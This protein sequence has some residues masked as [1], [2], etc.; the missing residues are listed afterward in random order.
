MGVSALGETRTQRPLGITLVVTSGLRFPASL[1]SATLRLSMATW[2]VLSIAFGLVSMLFPGVI[3]SL[4]EQATN[5]FLLG[6]WGWLTAVL[7]LGVL[8]ASRDPVRHILWLRIAIL[9]FAVGGAY[10]IAHVMADT[11]SLSAILADLAAYSIFGTLFVVFY[12]KAPRWMALEVRT[13]RGPLF[14]NVDEGGVFFQDEKTGA[15]ARYSPPRP[16][17][18]INSPYM[19]PRSG[20]FFPSNTFRP[21]PSGPDPAAWG[22]E[23][24]S[25]PPPNEPPGD[26]PRR[27]LP[28]RS[29]IFEQR[30]ER[31][32]S[33]GSLEPNLQEPQKEQE[34]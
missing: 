14:T 4:G 8:F 23:Q 17:P 1:R 11:A 22:P 31:F 5:T 15:F 10:N 24:P 28:P 33:H 29:N 18:P 32:P 12:P 3:G 21:D 2:G 6:S 34:E 7:G 30:A 25:A 16:N 27:V 9:S 19:P 20:S 13:Y 26:A